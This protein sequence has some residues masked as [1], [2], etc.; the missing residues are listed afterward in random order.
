MPVG[1]VNDLARCDMAEAVEDA[2]RYDKLVL[3]TTTYNSEIFPFMRYFIDQLKE[4]NFQKRTV[5]FIENGSWAPVANKIMKADFEDMKHMTIAK[6]NVTILSALNE[7]STAQIDALA[8][9]LSKGYLPVSAKTQAELDPTALFKIGYGLYV[10]TC[11]D[12]KKDNGLIVNTVTQ[13][14]DNPNRIAVNVNKANYSCEVI[15]N[16]GRLNVSVLSEDATFKI[17]EHFGFQS[18]K[19]VDKFAGYEHQAKAVNGLPYLTKHANAYISGNVTGMVDLGT[20]IMF[21][22]EVTESVKLSDIETMTYTYY[23]N[24]VKPK[25]ETDKKGCVFIWNT[26]PFSLFLFNRWQSKVHSAAVPR[27]RKNI[28]PPAESTAPERPSVPADRCVWQSCAV[29]RSAGRSERYANHTL[30][31]KP[32]DSCKSLPQRR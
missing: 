10:V 8:D 2:F 24:N 1:A 29:A 25:P 20:H 17:F 30:S 5:A 28:V 23:Q 11:N 32:D 21:I 22:C 15:K 19:N 4:R 16:T 27:R 26:Q 7:E 18:G 6:N 13:V 9:E 12:G 3:A 14:S 31:T